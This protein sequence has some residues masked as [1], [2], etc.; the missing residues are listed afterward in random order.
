[1]CLGSH[2]QPK[3]V[4][5]KGCE[6]WRAGAV[7]GGGGTETL[8]QCVMVLTCLERNRGPQRFPDL[9]RAHSG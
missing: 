3:G 2:Q 5:M 8:R 6:G 9:L 7:Q 1:M 4:W